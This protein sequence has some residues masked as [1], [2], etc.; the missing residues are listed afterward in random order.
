MEHFPAPLSGAESAFMLAQIEA[1][2]ERNGFGLWALE[3]ISSAR[4]IGL[5]GLSVVP[6]AA[7]F[8]PAVEVGWRLAAE[9]WGHGYAT[10]AA[11]AALDF[12]FAQAGLEEI[13]SFTS[14]RN[15]RSIAVMRRIGMHSEASEDFDHPLIE[16]EHPLRRHVL[17]R[18]RADERRRGAA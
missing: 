15:A 3:E 16:R 9:A 18:L 5:T 11:N 14:T 6:F 2:F 7:D 17:Y 10:E 1:G 4:F 12:G 13:V 8:T